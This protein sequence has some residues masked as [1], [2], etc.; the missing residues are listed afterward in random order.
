MRLL[1]VEPGPVLVVQGADLVDGTPILDIK[2]YLPYADSHP[3]ARSG[4][5]TAAPPQALSVDDPQ[6]LLATIPADLR[7]ALVESLAQDP[8]PHYQ[9]DPD[10][11][12]AMLFDRFEIK[13]RV[14]ATTATLTSIKQITHNS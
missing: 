9:D 14:T 13:F 10:R 2:P 5:A 6:G 8:R 12:Y 4:F 11:L 1:R 3:D 7:A